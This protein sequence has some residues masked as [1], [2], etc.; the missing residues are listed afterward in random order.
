MKYQ[1]RPLKWVVY[2]GFT[3]AWTP[4]GTYT[5]FRDSWVRSE[6]GVW[7]AVSHDGMSSIAAAEAACQADYEKRMLEYLT[8]AD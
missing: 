2:E 8:P 3:K 6:P 7:G 4:L 1:I 5:A